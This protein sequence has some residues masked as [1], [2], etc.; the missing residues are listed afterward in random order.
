MLVILAGGIQAGVTN[1]FSSSS[2]NSAAARLTDTHSLYLH[3]RLAGG[4]AAGAGRPPLHRVSG[5]LARLR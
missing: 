3:T 4:S 1:G 2:S 5:R